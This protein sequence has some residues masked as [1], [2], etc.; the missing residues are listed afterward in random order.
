MSSNR[1][2]T[3]WRVSQ[4]DKSSGIH[5]IVSEFPTL[6][7]AEAYQD[8]LVATPEYC[9]QCTYIRKAFSTDRVLQL[10]ASL[11]AGESLSVED[12]HWLYEYATGFQ[13]KE[14]VIHDRSC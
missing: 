11:E 2:D 12:Q 6:Q 13:V 1:A 14:D 8:K 10:R 7:E 5:Y 4:H 3:W 9:R